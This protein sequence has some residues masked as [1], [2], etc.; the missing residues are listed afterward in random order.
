MYVLVS[1]HLLFKSTTHI[2]EIVQLTRWAHRKFL[3]HFLPS[4]RHKKP[5]ECLL[6]P[7]ASKFRHS[8]HVNLKLWLYHWCL[9]VKRSRICALGFWNSL[10]FFSSKTGQRFWILTL[11]LVSTSCGQTA[12]LTCEWRR[13]IKYLHSFVPFNWWHLPFASYAFAIF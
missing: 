3:Q 9:G 7:L 4:S 2:C 10:C 6:L 13:L 8:Q 1:F 11:G 5:G 12:A